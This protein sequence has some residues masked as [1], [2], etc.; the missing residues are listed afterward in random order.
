M[1]EDGTTFKHFAWPLE[2]GRG[3]P[4]VN[5]TLWDEIA[6]HILASRL[7]TGVDPSLI[8]WRTEPHWE[9]QRDFER[10]VNV[11]ALYA[12]GAYPVGVAQ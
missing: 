11:S 5:A 9:R 1:S 10:M 8:W 3:G 2:S 12:R 4:L 7:I 6:E